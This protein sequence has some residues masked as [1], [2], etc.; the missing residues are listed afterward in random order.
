MQYQQN[1]DILEQVCVVDCDLGRAGV[2]NLITTRRTRRSKVMAAGTE[3]FELAPP[4]P[5][6]SR[7]DIKLIGDVARIIFFSEGFPIMENLKVPCKSV[8]EVVV[9]L[10]TRL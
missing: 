9:I 2:Q 5:V 3:G 8:R 6:R 4:L 7:F 1:G 10:E